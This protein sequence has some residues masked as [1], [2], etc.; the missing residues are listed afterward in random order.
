MLCLKESMVLNKILYEY[1]SYLVSVFIIDLKLIVMKKFTTCLA[2]MLLTLSLNQLAAQNTKEEKAEAISKQ[3]NSLINESMHFI[4]KGKA[5]GDYYFMFSSNEIIAYLPYE[6]N[7]YGSTAYKSIKSPMEFSS[8]KFD[9][10][11]TE[12]TKDS[13]EIEITLND[14]NDIHK[15]YFTIF[16]NGRANLTADGI[17]HSRIKYNGFIFKDNG[18]DYLVGR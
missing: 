12:K 9:Y 15:L 6:G 17:A 4:F 18:T 16:D 3:V 5:D 2:V 13:W 11:I 14:I 8:K 10:V 7:N 1:N